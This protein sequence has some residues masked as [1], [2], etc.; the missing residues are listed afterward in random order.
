MDN[1]PESIRIDV[2]RQLF[3]DDFLIQLTSLERIFHQARK[4]QASPVLVPET[5]VELNGGERPAAVPFND[6]AWYDP[7]DR[8]FKL[9]YY[10]GYDDGTAYAESED[11]IHWVQIGH[12]SQCGDNTTF[13]TILS[14]SGGYSAYVTNGW[15]VGVGHVPTT[16]MKIL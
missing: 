12:S 4:H 16:N 15:K 9:W 10:A 1:P 5:D 11:D 13:F 14:G 3:V 2:G 7:E 6:G 8:L